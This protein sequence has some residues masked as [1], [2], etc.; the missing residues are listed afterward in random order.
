VSQESLLQV[1]IIVIVIVGLFGVQQA[2]VVVVGDIIVLTVVVV[3]LRA[4]VIMAGHNII[5]HLL[6]RPAS[7]HRS[8]DITFNV[9]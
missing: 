3:V 7:S 6:F 8:S 1:V 4:W 5:S 9:I 2:A